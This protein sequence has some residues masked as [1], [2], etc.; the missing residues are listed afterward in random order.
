MRAPLAAWLAA[1]AE[2]ADGRHPDGYRV[3]DAGAGAGPYAG[4]F[5]GATEYVGVDLACG[6]DVVAPVEDLPLDDGSFELVLCTQV[7]EHADDPA[8]AVRELRRVVAADGRVLASTHGVQPYHPAPSDHWR[9]T[10]TGLERLFAQN[11]AWSSLTVAPGTGTTAC[12]G[13]VVAIYVDLLARRARLGV[14]GRAVVAGIN[15]GAEAL[16]QRVPEL[17]EPRPGSLFANFHVTAVA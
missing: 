8:R 15:A 10:H 1:E 12:V 7:L 5:A 2:A 3:L 13:M 4:L 16:D 11:G 17:R 9:W 6:A 14:L